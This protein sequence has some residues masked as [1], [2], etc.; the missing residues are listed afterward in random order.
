MRLQPDL[1]EIHTRFGRIAARVEGAIGD[2]RTG[3]EDAARQPESIYRGLAVRID[4]L[5][6]VLGGVGE[7]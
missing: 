1:D 2:A 3:D 7:A 4:D 5:M 6:P